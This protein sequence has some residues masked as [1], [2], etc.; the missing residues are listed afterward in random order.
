[1]FASWRHR[2][3]LAALLS[4]VFALP[5]RA[6]AVPAHDAAAAPGCTEFCGVLRFMTP[7]AQAEARHRPHA[8]ATRQ[9]PAP[10][11]RTVIASRATPPLVQYPRPAPAAS[12]PAWPYYARVAGVPPYAGRAYPGG[13]YP[14]GAYPSAAYPNRAWRVAAYPVVVYNGYGYVYYYVWSAY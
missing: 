2:L 10:H 5:R 12:R 7:P 9:A 11:R 3:L 1:M 4:L 14:R 6:S 13:A 8:T